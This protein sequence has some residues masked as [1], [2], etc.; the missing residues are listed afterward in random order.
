MC[1]ANAWKTQGT[2]K[3][4]RDLF[5]ALPLVERPLGRT[6]RA[7][8][9][10]PHEVGNGDGSWGTQLSFSDTRLFLDFWGAAPEGSTGIQKPLG[11]SG[12]QMAQAYK[13]PDCWWRQIRAAPL[14]D[15]LLGPPQTWGQEKPESPPVPRLRSL[16]G[17]PQP[18]LSRL[19]SCTA[20]WLGKQ[21]W[22]THRGWGGRA[23]LSNF[24]RQ[25]GP[26]SSMD[27]WRGRCLTHFEGSAELE[28]RLQR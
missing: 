20:C 3:T 22:G 23:G 28:S 7:Q 8:E 6:V 5:G 12:R 2:M 17:D 15:S 14:G 25:S 13:T 26:S 11:K 10:W 27:A 19:P 18:C 24:P 16:P 9:G 1:R 4:T 21:T